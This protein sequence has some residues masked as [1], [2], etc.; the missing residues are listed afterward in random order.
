M[1]ELELIADE[2]IQLLRPL[3]GLADS[4]NF[5]YREFPQHHR[6][7]GMQT[8]NTDNSLWVKLTSNILEGVSGVYVDDVIPAGTPGFDKLIHRL[9]ERYDAKDKELEDGCIAGI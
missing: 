5:W 1:T 7:M 6:D 2:A 9:G 4:G 3:H 8:L